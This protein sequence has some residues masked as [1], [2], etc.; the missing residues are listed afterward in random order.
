[1]KNQEANIEIRRVDGVLK[2]IS[3]VMP[4]WE[5]E[6]E[7]GIFAVEIPLFSTKTFAKN[8]NDA[9]V[10]L[11]E[12][13][14]SFCISADRFGKGL[15]NSLKSIGWN[16]ESQNDNKSVLVFKKKN[17]ILNQLMQTGDEFAGE[18]ELPQQSMQIAS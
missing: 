9:E 17:D 3:V 11:R 14:Q 16:L 4:V 10:A 1:M 7:D 6:E 2:S 8:E 13:I 12:A 18:L 5:K 15:E